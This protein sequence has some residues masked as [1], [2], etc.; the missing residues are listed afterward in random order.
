MDQRLLGLFPCGSHLGQ[1]FRPLVFGATSRVFPHTAIA[2][3]YGRDEQKGASAIA[4]PSVTRGHRGTEQDPPCFPVRRFSR[5]RCSLSSFSWL[6][7]GPAVR[8]S[9]GSSGPSSES[10][11]I[12]Q[13]KARTRSTFPGLPAQT[14]PRLSS[15]LHGLLGATPRPLVLP[16]PWLAPPPPGAPCPPVLFLPLLSSSRTATGQRSL[17]QRR[18]SHCRALPGLSLSSS[19]RATRFLQVEQRSVSSEGTWACEQAPDAATV[20]QEARGGSQG[21]REG[22]GGAAS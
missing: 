1:Q 13:Q 3:C 14:C 5:C 12:L 2:T 9:V 17:L 7:I 15:L 21:A 18:A 6:T 22:P 16:H 10:F 11:V 4:R 19:P 8:A 20:A